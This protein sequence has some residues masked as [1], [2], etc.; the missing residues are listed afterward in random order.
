MTAG[1]GMSTAIAIYHGRFGRA[2]LY[3]LDRPLTKPRTARVT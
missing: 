3:Q 1:E 2:S